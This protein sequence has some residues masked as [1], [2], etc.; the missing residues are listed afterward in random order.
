[1]IPRGSLKKGNEHQ[2]GIMV[3]FTAIVV[4]AAGAKQVSTRDRELYEGFCVSS[5]IG[6]PSKEWLYSEEYIC[7][8]RSRS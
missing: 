5:G 1:M 6:T 3:Q 4:T 8:C 2:K 7:S